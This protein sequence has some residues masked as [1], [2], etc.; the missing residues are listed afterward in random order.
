[1]SIKKPWK[2]CYYTDRMEVTTVV[3]GE[4]QTLTTGEIYKDGVQIGTDSFLRNWNFI[5]R[6]IDVGSD[7]TGP[8]AV[9]LGFGGTQ[10]PNFCGVNGHHICDVKP[11]VRVTLR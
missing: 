8:A 10:F 7:T 5:W 2:E 11:V 6:S 9:S 1:M 4:L 3:S